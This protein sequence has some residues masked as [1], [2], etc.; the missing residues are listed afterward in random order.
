MQNF[1]NR[2]HDILRMEEV[3][4]FGAQR[5]KNF[6]ENFENYEEGLN[7]GA[8]KLTE[9]GFSSLDIQHL[10]AARITD[11][12]LEEQLEFLE[13]RSDVN[14]VT[15]FDDQYPQ[16]LKEIY[17]PPLYLFYQGN[18]SE[19]DDISIGIVGSR[20]LSPYGKTV[21]TKIAADIA[22]AGFVVVSGLARGADSYAHIGALQEGKRTIAI[23]GSGIDKEVNF[24]SRR[25]REEILEKGGAVFSP[26]HIGEPASKYTFPSRNRIISG[27]SL[28]VLITEAR[29]RSGSLITASCAL[30]QGREVFAIPNPIFVEK[31][32]GTNNLI[33][34]GQAKLLMTVQDIIDEMSDYAKGFIRSAESKEEKKIV[35][36]KDKLE[37]KIYRILSRESTHIDKLS[38]ELDLNTGT[39]MSKLLIMELRNLI[40]REANNIFSIKIESI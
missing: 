18:L 31:F 16:N 17:D 38:E 19:Q 34:S 30:E 32:E 39:L 40:K 23:L 36:F 11:S 4:G 26:F 24:S 35:E 37:K 14:I 12:I 29:M 27:I 28:G 8:F 9:M 5:I 3:E 15:Y 22:E 7:A 20:E 33:K 1:G 25:V 2:L 13:K 21:T 10:Q 6:L